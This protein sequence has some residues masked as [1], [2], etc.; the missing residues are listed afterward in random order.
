MEEI[1]LATA[2]VTLVQL[3]LWLWL[4]GRA[5]RRIKALETT[6]TELRSNINSAGG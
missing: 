3:W 4:V 2:T 5:G 1:V 6:V